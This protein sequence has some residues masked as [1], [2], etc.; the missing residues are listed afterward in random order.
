MTLILS[1][2]V[3]PLFVAMTISAILDPLPMPSS[4]NYSSSSTANP[5]AKDSNVDFVLRLTGKDW[6]GFS[7]S[8][9]LRV[10][11][12]IAD[13]MHKKHPV[14]TTPWLYRQ[15]N[16]FF[17]AGF[18]ESENVFAIVSALIVVAENE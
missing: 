1:L 8:E 17:R 3:L 14:V 6:H 10:C 11:G 18:G 2:T 9:K 7:N 4:E 15:L 16:D 5:S 13:R 12:I